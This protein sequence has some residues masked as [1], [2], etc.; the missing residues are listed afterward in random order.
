[1]LLKHKLYASLALAIL[2]PLG[3]STLL[4]SQNIKNHASEKLVATELPTIL[5]DVRNA[6]EL[7]LSA[8]LTTS[9]DL[10]KNPFVVDWFSKGEPNEQLSQFGDYL[11]VIKQQSQT[12]AVYL[13]SG[14]TDRYYNQEGFQ[15]EI[16]KTGDDW[17]YHFVNSSKPYEISLGFDRVTGNVEVYINYVIEVNG[18]R[19]GLGGV[20]QSLSTMTE[21][22]KSYKIGSSGIVYL[23]DPSGE[24]KLHPDVEKIGEKIDLAGLKAGELEEFERDG[25][26]FGRAEVPLRSVDWRLVAEVSQDELYG[27]I[28]NAIA[29]NLLFGVVI[30][31]IGLILIRFVV[32]QIF[33]PV[34]TITQAVSELSK[35]GGDLTSRLSVNDNNEIS[36]LAREF[37][38]FIEQLHAMFKQVSASAIQVQELS[39]GV[40]TKVSN[41]AQLAENQSQSTQT[42]VSAVN[43]MEFTV[44]D[45]SNSAASGSDIASMSRK[46]SDKGNEYVSQT[47]SQMEN[48][49]NSMSS[50][51]VS[52]GELSSE[53][54]SITN[55]LDVINGI[56]E[57]TNLLA[58]NAAIEAARAGEQG[59]GFAVVADEVRVLARRTS[60]ST[61][62][63]NDT[64]IALNQKAES[65]VKSIESGNE[66]TLNTSQRLDKTEATL[67]DISRE[68]MSISQINESVATATKEQMQS[69]SHISQ[70]IAD[71]S[72]SAE[73]TKLNMTDS[74]VLCT[75][76]SQESKV[77]KKLINQ[78]TL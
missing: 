35:N 51:V 55:L 20:S 77:L 18:Q 23:V 42:V 60:E 24:I 13:V 4:F 75:E 59:R 76:L 73:Q 69:A 8:P 72:Q 10:T 25:N 1:M 19:V 2:I 49:Q 14:V 3:I 40:Q 78:F 64:I 41:A 45:I 7:E 66:S 17:F 67:T 63:I 29:Q 65:A 71:I 38:Q 50:T 53:I 44:K 37:N 9:R 46:T 34:E 43:Q 5:S 12:Q 11:S 54:Q 26:I 47:K 15:R 58:L 52:V 56:S 36:W 70:N 74:S 31:V 39:D 6:I 16:T 30:A 21:L 57:Q 62:Q 32:N 61:E 27:P 33:Q 48:L 28:N 22:I 68:I